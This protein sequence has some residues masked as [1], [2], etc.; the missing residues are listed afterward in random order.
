[1]FETA[2]RKKFRYPFRGQI[3]T[4]DLWDLN[5]PELDSVYKAL[6]KEAKAKDDGESLITENKPDKEL[7]L[8]IDIVKHVF[9]TKQNEMK[10]YEEEIVRAKKKEKLLDIL[11]RKQDNSLEQMSE[12]ELKKAIEE[13][14]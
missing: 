3:S 7:L 9:G 10:K 5:L 14:S 13:L 1:M 4:E 12:E 6:T 8:K 2:T 11:A